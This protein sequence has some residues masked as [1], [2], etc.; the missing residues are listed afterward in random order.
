LIRGRT[1]TWHVRWRRAVT[2][3]GEATFQYFTNVLALD[4]A[5]REAE[6]ERLSLIMPYEPLKTTMECWFEGN[7]FK[8]IMYG[9]FMKQVIHWT[10]LDE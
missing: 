3:S 1:D 7:E 5:R 8:G 9:R 2:K 6:T 10:P 4:I